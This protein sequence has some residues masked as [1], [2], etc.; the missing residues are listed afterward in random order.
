MST[1][2]AAVAPSVAAI[3]TAS[4]NAPLLLFCIVPPHANVF[5]DDYHKFRVGISPIHGFRGKNQQTACHPSLKR[6]RLRIPS[7]WVAPLCAA[8]PRWSSFCTPTAGGTRAYRPLASVGGRTLPAH[9]IRFPRREDRG[10]RTRRLSAHRPVFVTH[11]TQRV[12]QS[13]HTARAHFPARIGHNTRP[14][15]AHAHDFQGLQ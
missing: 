1:A 3:A 15:A 8:K 13:R 4:L 7:R 12:T 6:H 2:P 9:H 11:V 5:A 10:P 14:R